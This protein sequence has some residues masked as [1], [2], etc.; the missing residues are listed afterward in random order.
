VDTDA[1]DRITRRLKADTSRRGVVGSV[2]GGMAALLTSMGQVQGARKTKTWLCHRPTNQIIDP[3]TG[4]PDSTKINRRR[5]TVLLVA[6]SAKKDRNERS[7][8][9]EKLRGH[10]RHGDGVCPDQLQ[11]N[12]IKGS[13]C[14]VEVDGVGNLVRADRLAEWCSLAPTND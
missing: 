4:Q 3:L 5:G 10:L 13:D 1:F 14:E 12:L 7:R 9:Q 11:A 6:E 2:L 8:K